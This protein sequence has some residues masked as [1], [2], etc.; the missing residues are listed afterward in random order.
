MAWRE[1]VGKL[2]AATTAKLARQE[3]R[4]VQRSSS[5]YKEDEDGPLFD[6]YNTL[7][8]VGP[9]PAGSG[10]TWLQ[11]E[12]MIR[13]DLCTAAAANPRHNRYSNLFPYDSSRIVV[14][15]AEND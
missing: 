3:E 7:E 10:N 1:R 5:S 12:E 15:G 14:E 9:A 2:L 13:L 6:E 8:L 11:H 4:D